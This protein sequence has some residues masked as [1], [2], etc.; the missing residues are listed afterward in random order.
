MK[1]VLDYFLVF[2]PSFKFL[3]EVITGVM[4]KREVVDL[5]SYAANIVLH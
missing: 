5:L 1:F 2:A 4:G 3:A